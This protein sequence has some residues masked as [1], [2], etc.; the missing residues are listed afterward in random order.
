MTRWG[1]VRMS[2]SSPD[3]ANCHARSKRRL[4][5]RAVALI[6]GTLV[7]LVLAE[8]GVRLIVNEGDIFKTTDDQVYFKYHKGQQGI[9]VSQSEPSLRVP[10]QINSHGYRGPEWPADSAAEI[11]FLGDSFTVAMEVPYEE[12]FV[13][14]LEEKLNRDGPGPACLNLGVDGSGIGLALLR[15]EREVLQRRPRAVVLQF[16]VGNDFSDNVA[17][18]SW[19]NYYPHWVLERGKLVL[20]EPEREVPWLMEVCRYSRAAAFAYRRYREFARARVA[21]PV[22]DDNGLL[23]PAE[24]D[25]WGRAYEVTLALLERFAEVAEENDI[26]LVVLIIPTSEQVSG[27]LAGVSDCEKLSYPQRAIVAKMEGR[28]RMVDLLPHLV[29]EARLLDD[30]GWYYFARDGHFNPAGHAFVAEKLARFVEFNQT[31]VSTDQE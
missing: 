21:Q 24:S 23:R 15:L 12:C 1:N 14:L 11:A 3:S 31:G 10:V 8:V 9:R 26:P 5:P 19:K 18:L 22:A 30:P 20:V 29:A 25:A 6:A 4:L 7:A 27:C 28:A 2:T 13:S 17:E 16:F